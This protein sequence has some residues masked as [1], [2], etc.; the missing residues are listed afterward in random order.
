M[1]LLA[2]FGGIYLLDGLNGLIH[3][4]GV[5]NGKIFMHQVDLHRIVSV[6][7]TFQEYF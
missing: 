6:L 7:F 5:H 2:F 3:E 1:L 4:Q